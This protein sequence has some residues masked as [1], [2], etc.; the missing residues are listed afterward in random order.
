MFTFT[1]QLTRSFTAHIRRFSSTAIALTVKSQLKNEAIKFSKVDVLGPGKLKRGII[2]LQEALALVDR[3]A[4][5]LVLVDDTKDPPLCRIVLKESKIKKNENA[6]KHQSTSS[7]SKKDGSLPRNFD[8]SCPTVFVTG[9]GAERPGVMSLED[10][11]KL[12]NRATQ[13]LVL[14]SP[15]QDPPVCRIV[16]R[17]NEQQKQEEIKKTHK[18]AQRA[19]RTVTGEDEKV[20]TAKVNHS[21][22]MKEIELKSSISSHDLQ[23]KLRK[24]QELLKKGYRVQVTVFEAA[25][26]NKSGPGSGAQLL[27]EVIEELKGDGTPLGQPTVA[28]RKRII[29]F[30]SS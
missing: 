26:T 1:Q 6:R 5:D 30:K 23:I 22:E 16:D 15:N 17:V 19:Q 12:V 27:D 8:I 18:G 13:D 4:Q 21:N 9:P 2:N 28:G 3:S 20:S 29:V 11:M 25:G 14:V 24:V 10:A 7:L